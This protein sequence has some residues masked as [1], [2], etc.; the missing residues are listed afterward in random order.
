MKKL[1]KLVVILLLIAIVIIALISRFTGTGIRVSDGR[2]LGYSGKTKE[3]LF[4]EYQNI[5]VRQDGPY[6][7]NDSGKDT[8]LT[9][10]S[11]EQ[12]INKVSTET[13]SNEVI[14]TTKNS[15]YRSSKAIL[16]SFTA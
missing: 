3:W 6:V 1:L 12:A 14:V 8:A 13:V 4:I 11:S 7:L 2:Y 5:L 15:V 9:I 10:E 16:P